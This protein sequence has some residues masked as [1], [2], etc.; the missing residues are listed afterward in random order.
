MFSVREVKRGRGVADLSRYKTIAVA[1]TF[2]ICVGSGVI[3]GQIV[4][5]VQVLGTRHAEWASD[6]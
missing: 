2:S 4:Q 6:P 5:S 1:A 3:L